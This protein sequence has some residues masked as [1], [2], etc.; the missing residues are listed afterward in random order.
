MEDLTARLSRTDHAVLVAIAR[1]VQMTPSE[2]LTFAGQSLID[3]LT[4]IHAAMSKSDDIRDQVRD[5]V[6]YHEA[7]K[8]S[9]DEFTAALIEI[10]EM[11]GDKDAETW[12]P[13]IEV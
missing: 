3:A 7:G 2:F 5:L 11:A 12:T 6:T 13:D 10:G 9:A 8:L 4:G 1:M